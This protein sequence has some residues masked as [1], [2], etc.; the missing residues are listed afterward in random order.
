M[1]DE[2]EVKPSEVIANQ[3][4]ERQYLHQRHPGVG[5]I[6]CSDSLQLNIRS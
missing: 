6:L 5:P 3:K 4:E 2:I 1:L